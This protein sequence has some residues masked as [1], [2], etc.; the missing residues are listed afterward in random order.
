MRI[1]VSKAIAALALIAVAS[2]IAIALLADAGSASAQIDERRVLATT[3]ANMPPVVSADVRRET[4]GT[5]DDAAQ[6]PVIELSSISEDRQHESDPNADDVKVIHDFTGYFSDPDNQTLSF[7]LRGAPSGVFRLVT[8]TAKLIQVGDIEYDNID[9]GDADN[10]HTAGVDANDD[11]D[12]DDNGDTKPVLQY[13]FS[14]VAS[15]GSAEA[16]IEVTLPITEG[17]I[18]DWTE[19]LEFNAAENN[20]AGY[21]VG[22][23]IIQEYRTSTTLTSGYDLINDGSQNPLIPT[24]RVD[25]NGRPLMARLFKIDDDGD[26]TIPVAGALDYEPKDTYILVVEAGPARQSDKTIGVVTVNVTDVNEAPVFGASFDDDGDFETPTSAPEYIARLYE[27]ADLGDVVFVHDGVNHETQ[28][29][30]VRAADQDN[31]Q[32]VTLAYSLVDGANTAFTGPF[33]INKNAAGR[34][35]IRVTGA[36]NADVKSSYSLFIRVTD[37]GGLSADAPLTITVRGLNENITPTPTRTAA[38]PTPTRTPRVAATP[39]P[40]TTPARVSQDV[41]RRVGALEQLL[42]TLQTLIQS[43]QGVIAAQDSRIAAQ[44]SRIAAQDDKIAAQDGRIAALESQIAAAATIT[45]T[46]PPTA[47]PSPTP[48]ATPEPTAAAASACVQTI[49]AGSVSGSWTSACLTANPTHGNTYYARFY[50]FTLDAAADVSIALTSDKPPYLYLLAG[51]GTA[52]DVLRQAGGNNQT[53]IAITDTLQAGSYTIEASTWQPKT[54]GDFT[55]TLT[56]RQ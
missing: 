36:L 10:V 46:P 11:G 22:K 28:G 2:L 6:V 20:P 1:S 26:L 45:P 31:G 19:G 29:N 54:L 15:D 44:D 25:V 3:A 38:T 51:A 16:L 48:T 23:V 35:V 52:G 42:A 50:T 47:T 7:S 4:R 53:S 17:E 33:A 21:E 9:A 14:V 8:N 39:T 55:L 37:S 49:G 30:P 24:G 56:A 32:T 34:P 40:T 18:V 5:G 27:G 41:L 13:V 12:F 43:L